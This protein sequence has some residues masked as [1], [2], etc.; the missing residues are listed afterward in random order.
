MKLA[1]ISIK[2]PVFAFMMSA[3]IVVL[4]IASYSQLGLECLQGSLLIDRV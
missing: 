2:R 1:D 4:G 3:A